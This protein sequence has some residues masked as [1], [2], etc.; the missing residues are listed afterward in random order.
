MPE[1]R[2]AKYEPAARNALEMFGIAPRSL[3]P[4]P[5]SENVTFHV[6]DAND[7]REYVLRLHRPGYRTLAQ[8]E[9]E[10]VWTEAL[11][12]SGITVPRARST[13]GGDAFGLVDIDDTGERRYAG[14]LEWIPGEALSAQISRNTDSRSLAQAMATLGELAA[15][16][17]EHSSRWTAPAGFQRPHL[18]A[19][20]LLGNAPHWGRFWDHPTW[21]A[22][23]RAAVLATRDHLR[24]RLDSLDHDASRYGMVHADLHAENI[25]IDRNTLTVIDFDDSSYGWYCY[26]IATTLQ[27]LTTR[28]EYPGLRAAL[29]S[30]YRR[31][32]PFGWHDEELLDSLQV[33]RGLSSIGW[34]LQRPEVEASEPER[35]EAAKARALRGC[36]SVLGAAAI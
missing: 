21:T 9:S 35:F 18:N 33:V 25:V 32:R 5:V 27:P 13:I 23:E 28:P 3:R 14:I 17:H 31:I 2:A 22:S 8:L 19:E 16:M 26:D 30:A 7:G 4:L 15:R 6:T 12:A 29:L 36:A 1:H 11:R 20:T 10:R 24:K 34:Y